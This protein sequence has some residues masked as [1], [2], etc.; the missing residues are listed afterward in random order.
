[1]L[2]RSSAS[3]MGVDLPVPGDS[4][5]RRDSLGRMPQCDHIAFR[6]A[7]LERTI[8]F[9][10]ELLPGKV[11]ARRKSRDFWRTEIA[12]IEPEGQPGFTL[13][14]I[15]P[16]RV[17]WLLFLFHLLTPR[18]IRSYEHVGL[19]CSSREE[20][21]QRAAA[22]LAYGAKLLHPP[23]FVDEQVGY[24]A[25]TVDPDGNPVEWTYGQRVKSEPSTERKISS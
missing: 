5:F 23:S 18:Q 17:R 14:F 25:E 1:M 8:R 24:V 16:G 6:V 3:G 9:Y 21:D 7:D 4:S 19:A 15:Q 11:V 12:W 22:A 10:E 20:V 2:F 13:V